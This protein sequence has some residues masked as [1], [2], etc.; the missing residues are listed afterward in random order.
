MTDH[1]PE[2]FASNPTLRQVWEQEM[3]ARRA[4]KDEPPRE[5]TEIEAYYAMRGADWSDILRRRWAEIEE[6]RS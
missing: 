2:P 1:I 5:F 3:Q 4:G 6:S